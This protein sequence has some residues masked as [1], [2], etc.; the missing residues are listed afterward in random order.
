[1][2]ECP[3]CHSKFFVWSEEDNQYWYEKHIPFCDAKANKARLKKAT[4]KKEKK[5]N[6][7]EKFLRFL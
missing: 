6:G 1:M 4:R 3:T 2:I 5:N 7:P